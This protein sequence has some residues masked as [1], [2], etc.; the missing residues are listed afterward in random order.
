MPRAA[1]VLSHSR[2]D[3][4]QSAA[5]R[6]A[7]HT[8][9]IALEYPGG[10]TVMLISSQANDTPVDHELR[11]HKATLKFTPAGFTITPQKMF[12]KDMQAIE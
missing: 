9:N 7:V 12:A 3:S 1:R 2:F 11:G 6:S 5:G 4:S 8:F 10:P